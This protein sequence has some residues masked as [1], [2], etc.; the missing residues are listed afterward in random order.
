MNT[1]EFANIV[2]SAARVG[3]ASRQMRVRVFMRAW[4]VFS[5]VR[6]LAHSSAEPYTYWQ[7]RLCFYVRVL[8]NPARPEPATLCGVV[9]LRNVARP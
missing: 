9:S 1:N 4:Y 6:F 2:V 3:S 7:Q 8:D 5:A